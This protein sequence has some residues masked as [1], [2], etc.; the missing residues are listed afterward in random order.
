MVQNLQE[1]Y[2]VADIFAAK[3][4]LPVDANVD[5]RRVQLVVPEERR[6]YCIVQWIRVS[7]SS[8]SH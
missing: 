8:F 6:D 2:K 5:A 3:D 4:F 7:S 1:E